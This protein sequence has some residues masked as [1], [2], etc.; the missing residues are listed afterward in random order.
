MSEHLEQAL[1]ELI[2]LP[3]EKREKYAEMILDRFDRDAVQ[4]EEVDSEM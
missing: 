4:I 1:Y 3:E 2:T